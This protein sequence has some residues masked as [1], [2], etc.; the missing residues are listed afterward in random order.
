[1]DGFFELIDLLRIVDGREFPLSKPFT[2]SLF[3]DLFG[4]SPV[5]CKL[6]VS[7]F[8]RYWLFRTDIYQG[9]SSIS[10]SIVNTSASQEC[11]LIQED[12]AQMRQLREM[13][14]RED[15]YRVGRL[16]D[17]TNDSERHAITWLDFIIKA[18]TNYSRQSRSER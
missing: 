11:P 15:K 9:L 18:Q 4:F 1:V 7:N 3:L 13:F 16:S 8:N 12:T 6:F 14:I 10:A 5:D 2:Q 17:S